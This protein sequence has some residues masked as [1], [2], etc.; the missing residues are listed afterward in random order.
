[1]A[2]SLPVVK[3]EAGLECGGCKECCIAFPLLPNEEY[4]PE[5]KP[6]YKPCRFLCE[7]G[8]SI[9]EMPRPKVCTSFRCLY[10]HGRFGG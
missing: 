2:F 6:A 1:M 4:W 8:C 7:S 3:K 10:A 9:H 5:G